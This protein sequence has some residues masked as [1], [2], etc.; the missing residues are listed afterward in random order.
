MYHIGKIIK[1]YK[2]REKELGVQATVDMWDDNILTLEVQKKIGNE[3]KEGK[4]VLVDYR[5]YTHLTIAQ[6]MQIISRVLEN[7]EGEEVWGLYKQ[8]LEK[9]KKTVVKPVPVNIP[10]VYR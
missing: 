8:R 10:D 2:K 3:L 9:L 6:P 5:P 4:F 7:K 1:V